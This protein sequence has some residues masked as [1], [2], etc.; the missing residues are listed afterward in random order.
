MDAREYSKYIIK[1]QQQREKF[2]KILLAILD[3][4]GAAGAQPTQMVQMMSM[5]ILNTFFRVVTELRTFS[6]P[7]ISLEM[8]LDYPDRIEFGKDRER[9]TNNIENGDFLAARRNLIS[10]VHRCPVEQDQVL[11]LIA[12]RQTGM[13]EEDYFEVLE[14]ENSVL[15][16][17]NT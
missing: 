1:A 15:R 4:E 17:R 5:T 6:T 14:S 10:I 3:E 12:L 9:L 2:R 13:M 11:Y 8:L 7:S 16:P